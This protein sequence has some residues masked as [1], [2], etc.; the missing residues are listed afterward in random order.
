MTR[1]II[2]E[3][4]GRTLVCGCEMLR[5]DE[6]RR[7]IELERTFGVDFGESWRKGLDLV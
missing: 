2:F 4:F 7:R 1:D 5:D 6:K 3:W